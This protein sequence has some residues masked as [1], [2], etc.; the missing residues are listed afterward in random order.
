MY[1]QNRNQK[2]NL[3]TMKHW[4]HTM[5]FVSSLLQLVVASLR[6]TCVLDNRVILISTYQDS[7]LIRWHEEGQKVAIQFEPKV[8]TMHVHWEL[9]DTAWHMSP[10]T[11]TGQKCESQCVI[12]TYV[13]TKQEKAMWTQCS[14][15]AI[16]CTSIGSSL[17]LLDTCP[18]SPVPLPRPWTFGQKLDSNRTHPQSPPTPT[19]PNK[20]TPPSKL[21][22]S[23]PDLSIFLHTTW[24]TFYLISPATISSHLV[25]IS[26]PTNKPS[27]GFFNSNCF[28]NW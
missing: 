6:L 19:P 9:P 12:S 7:C 3:N 8:S 22:I 24:V 13:R 15:D 28:I 17:I 25:K 26:S 11:S 1:E 23:L 2:V 27:I 14:I 16:Q 4:W 10:L 20:L 18:P 5:H 21:H